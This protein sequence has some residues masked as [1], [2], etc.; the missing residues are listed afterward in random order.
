MRTVF[1]LCQDPGR[2]QGILSVGPAMDWK[3]INQSTFFILY[4]KHVK[5]KIKL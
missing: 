5:I 2:Q 1:P 4:V 3:A